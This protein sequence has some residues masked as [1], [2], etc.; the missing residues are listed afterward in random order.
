MVAL[1]NRNVI[2]RLVALVLP[3]GRSRKS[4][5]PL[6]SLLALSTLNAQLTTVFAQ[7]SAFS[8]QGR[9][10]DNTNPA[11]GIY[12]LRFTVY[13]S[14][15]TPG[16]L[17]AG[18]MTNAA[19]RVANGLFSVTLDFGADVFTGRG[20]WL[21]VAVR[22]NGGGAFTALAPR[23]PLL[24]SPY[25]VMA[26][27]ASNLLGTLPAV[28][29]TG[30]LPVTA[31]PSSAL[32]NN[33][34]GVT[35]NGSFVGNGAGLTN[36]NAGSLAP[37]FG[38]VPSGGIVLSATASN[39]ALTSAG[40]ALMVNPLG[41]GWTQATNPAPWGGRSGFGAVALNGQ[42]WVMGGFTD[43]G[44]TNDVWS[45]SNGVTWTQATSSAPWG[46]RIGFGAVV[47][48][49]QMWVMGGHDGAYYSD[50]WSSS[51]GVTW[52]RAT[53]AAS[54]GGRIYI[55]A[56]AFNG[57]MWVMGGTH[58][59]SSLLNDV[60]SSSNGVTWTQATNTAAW[61]GRLWF[62]VV[63]F[64]GQ[65]WV[66]GG[67]GGSDV[68]SSSN[69]VTWTQA[70][71]AAPWGGRDGFGAVVF[72]GQMWVMG[73]NSGSDVWSS[74]NGVTWTRATSAAPWGGRNNFGVLALNG[75]MWVMGGDSGAY[76]SDVWLLQNAAML[77]GFYLFQKQ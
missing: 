26:S 69:G 71:S 30:T 49:G 58:D 41:E 54:W 47:F 29:L 27:S 64:N 53:S 28:Q 16:N 20:R 22:T 48:N 72:N 74:S 14:A 18:P 10:N 35:L 76:Y 31:L 34:S 8:Y 60:W 9:L 1:N 19:T 63:A 21:E 15:N 4:L 61:G 55:G 68:W 65:M 17:I 70:T 7:G 24:P 42:M 39:A 57:Q 66:M 46:G 32:T 52:T 38:V 5:L 6:L 36:L 77:G 67:N 2:M 13:D 56:V 23:Q 44:Y 45:S 33:A 11:N 37:G 59:G 62:G 50:V 75:Q 40:F 73:G 51:N 25:A 43:Y 12:D 3:F